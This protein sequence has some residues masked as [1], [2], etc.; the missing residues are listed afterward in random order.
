MIL[1]NVLVGLRGGLHSSDS[2]TQLLRRRVS[3]FPYIL[4][5]KTLNGKKGCNSTKWG[6]DLGFF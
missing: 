6:R 5:F 4:D 3:V 1:F 2:T